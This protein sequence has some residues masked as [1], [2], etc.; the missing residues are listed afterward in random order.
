MD[1]LMVDYPPF[2]LLLEEQIAIVPCLE[3]LLR[4]A[5]LSPHLLYERPILCLPQGNHYLLLGKPGPFH[6]GISFWSWNWAQYL[7][8][9]KR[10]HFQGE[11]Q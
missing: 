7:S 10:S 1:A 5:N 11:D 3:S 2:H 9:C 6:P 4:Y 8:H